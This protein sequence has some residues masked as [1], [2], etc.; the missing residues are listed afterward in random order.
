MATSVQTGGA[1]NAAPFGFGT[2]VGT[3]SGPVFPG[4]TF[5]GITFINPSPTV[6]VAICPALV[7]LAVLGVYA[8]LATGVAVING[9][10]S[11]TL[12]PGDKFIIDNQQATTAWNGIASGAGGLLTILA[13]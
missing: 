5:G 12:N 10:G 13:F 3:V 8:G 6:A 2:T 4:G 7:N 9:A 11:I 1:T